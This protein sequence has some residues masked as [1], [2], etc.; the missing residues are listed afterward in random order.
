MSQFPRVRRFFTWLVAAVDLSSL[1][2]PLV[3]QRLHPTRLSTTLFG[4]MTSVF[5]GP[6]HL[7]PSMRFSIDTH[8]AGDVYQHGAELGGVQSPDT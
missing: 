7:I 1:S 3:P 2:F 6:T 8:A 5:R 4:T